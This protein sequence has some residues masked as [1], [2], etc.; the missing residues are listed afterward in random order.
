MLCS[1]NSVSI[2]LESEEPGR[3]RLSMESEA[4][5]DGAS[6]KADIAERFERII[7]GLA[8]Q[9][10][11]TPERDTETGRFSVTIAIVGSDDDTEAG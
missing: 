5:A 11:S 6:C 1:C 2:A 4:L 9:L 7:T 10:R 8:R 3:A